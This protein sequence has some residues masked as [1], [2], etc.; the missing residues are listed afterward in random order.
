MLKHK[1]AIYYQITILEW[2]PIL[3]SLI[4]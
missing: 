3:P 4:N 2:L 1:H